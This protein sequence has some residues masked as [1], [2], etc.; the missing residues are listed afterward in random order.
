[1]TPLSPSALAS[2]GASEV[3]LDSAPRCRATPRND[4]RSVGSRY[5]LHGVR[6]IGNIGLKLL[7][8]GVSAQKLDS[9]RGCEPRREKGGGGMSEWI[10]P[11]AACDT[12]TKGV[13]R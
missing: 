13:S 10:R 3:L 5:S 6:G 9:R 8:R 11:P 7:T 12:P 2:T 1:M 4:T